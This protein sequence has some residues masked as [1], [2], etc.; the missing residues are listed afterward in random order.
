M[1]NETPAALVDELAE[2]NA[3]ID[4]LKADA[5]LIKGQLFVMGAGTYQSDAYKA[6]VSQIGESAN[7]NYRKVADYLATKVSAQVFRNALKKATGV[8]AGYFKVSLYDLGA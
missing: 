1:T 6:V 2:I 8:K 4:A 7:V 5:E 3:R